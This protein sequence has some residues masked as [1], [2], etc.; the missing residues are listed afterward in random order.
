MLCLFFYADNVFFFFSSV[1]SF[2]A[3]LHSNEPLPTGCSLIWMKRKENIVPSCWSLQ[4][5]LGQS[6]PIQADPIQ[7]EKFVTCGRPCHVHLFKLSNGISVNQMTI[8]GWFCFVLSCWISYAKIFLKYTFF[9]NW[10]TCF[11]FS[12]YILEWMVEMT[13]F[14]LLMFK[15]WICSFRTIS[16]STYLYC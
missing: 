1:T 5:R 12:C 15:I 11:L 8:F 3:S 4:H 16:E 14:F 9:A 10:Q 13:D 2:I 6:S 7:P